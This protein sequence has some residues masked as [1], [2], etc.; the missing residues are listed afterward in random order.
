MQ[1][2][3]MITKEKEICHTVSFYLKSEACKLSQRETETDPSFLCDIA[4]GY[5]LNVDLFPVSTESHCNLSSLP[6]Q[7]HM[8]GFTVYKTECYKMPPGY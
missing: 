1:M 4:V 6:L 8:Y 2:W 3:P 5:Y 7:R